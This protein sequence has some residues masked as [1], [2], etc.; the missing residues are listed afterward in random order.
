[1]AISLRQRVAE[2]APGDFYVEPDTCLQCCLPHEEAPE[3]MNDCNQAFRECYFRRQP[4]TP[5]EVEHAIQAIWVSELNCL[6]YGGS[7]QA[8]IRRLHE[9]GREDCCDQPLVGEPA[10]RRPKRPVT[11]APLKK[12]W[13]QRLFGGAG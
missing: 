10:V 12:S 7:D 6:R 11:S 1:M 2:N 5:E 8:I 13:W 9:L 4:Q 3:L